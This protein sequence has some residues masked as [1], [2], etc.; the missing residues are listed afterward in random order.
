[1]AGLYIAAGILIQTDGTLCTQ[2]LQL[3]ALQAKF[4]Y[5]NSRPLFEPLAQSISSIMYIPVS[6]AQQSQSPHW[7]LNIS[8]SP[9]LASTA[10][11][12][13]LA[14]D[15]DIFSTTHIPLPIPPLF[16]A[17]ERAPP[18]AG[19]SIL[20][21]SA[22]SSTLDSQPSA[23]TILLFTRSESCVTLAKK[24]LPSIPPSVA[25]IKTRDI[26]SLL[27]LL[28]RLDD[29]VTKEV[30][31]VKENIKE[32]QELVRA[33]KSERQSNQIDGTHTL[34][35]EVMQLGITS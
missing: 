4:K 30:I 12:L 11:L 19:I 20:T 33:Y 15:D 14:Q 29:D 26:I 13:Q 22:T 5:S 18:C 25:L 35:A 34:G 27:H 1:M 8:R 9:L 3:S 17:Y 10:M 2:C 23:R 32:A 6:H 24:P 28:D 16:S 31:R 21:T 7:P